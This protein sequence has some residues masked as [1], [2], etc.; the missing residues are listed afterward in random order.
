[1]LYSEGRARFFSRAHSKRI[2]SCWV[3]EG[4]FQL[5]IYSENSSERDWGSVRT[6][7]ALKP[8]IPGHF[9]NLLG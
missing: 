3:Q 9:P 8:S 7:C 5:Y 1:M 6:G 4:K 2:K